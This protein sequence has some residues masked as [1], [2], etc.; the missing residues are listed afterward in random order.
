M[1]TII[2]TV[3]ITLLVMVVCVSLT[4]LV[5]DKVY[6]IYR[7]QQKLYDQIEKLEYTISEVFQEGK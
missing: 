1:I 3:F 5:K 6:D 2:C 4:K 7:N